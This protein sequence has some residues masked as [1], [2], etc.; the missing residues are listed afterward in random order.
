MTIANIYHKNNGKM[1]TKCS[2]MFKKIK[3]CVNLRSKT[4]HA[5]IRITRYV[6]KLSNLYSQKTKNYVK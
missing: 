4:K 2:K 3:N 6:Q 5:F 1:N